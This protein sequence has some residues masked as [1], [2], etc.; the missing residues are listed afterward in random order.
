MQPTRTITARREGATRGWRAVGATPSPS[1]GIRT[2]TSTEAAAGAITVAR[3]ARRA[4]AAFTL[5]ELLIV[6]G[7]IVLIVALAVPAVNAMTGGRSVDAATNQLSA[8]LGRVRM[9]AIGLQEPRG[10]MFYRDTA[11]QRIAARIV[12]IASSDLATGIPGFDLVEDRDAMLLPVGVGLQMVD[13]A[14]MSGSGPTATARDDRYIGYNKRLGNDDTLVPVGGDQ[15]LISVLAERG[16]EHSADGQVVIDDEHALLLDFLQLLV[17]RPAALLTD[18]HFRRRIL[19]TDEN[20]LQ[21]AG[22]RAATRGRQIAGRA[23]KT[24]RK[25][26]QAGNRPRYGACHRH[27]NQRGQRHGHQQ[28]H[29]KNIGHLP[30]R[31]H[32][33]RAVLQDI[34]APVKAGKVL[35]AI[36][37]GVAAEFF[38]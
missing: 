23:H 8:M 30:H 18:V 24:Q 31:S 37:L 27:R 2:D 29:Q 20:G 17:L 7:L 9:E 26:G 28:Q 12:R 38:C 33:L 32:G 13:D 19:P 5:T 10:L 6:I 22:P 34:H 25:V 36:G 11:T 16:R 15:N 3:A 14:A 1:R 4:R 21:D 35:V